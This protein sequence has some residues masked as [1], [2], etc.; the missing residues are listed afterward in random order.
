MIKIIIYCLLVYA[1]LL[2]VNLVESRIETSSR[3]I[4]TGVATCSADEECILHNKC[5]EVN[6]I[7]RK[8]FL[9]IDERKYLRSRLCRYI[10][11]EHHFC[12]KKKIEKKR[13]LP[14]VPVCGLVFSDRIFSS[15]EDPYIDKYPWTAI[16]MYTTPEN[17]IES[18]CGGSLITERHVLTAAHCNFRVP[19]T[20]KI[21]KVRLGE[22]DRRTNPDCMEFVNEQVC[23]DPFVDVQVMKVI[24]HPNYKKES[25][26]QFNDIAILELER[27]VKFTE[28][29]KP[30]C[31]PVDLNIRN[32]NFTSHSVE[33]SGFK[34]TEKDVE[35]SSPTKKV[36]YLY[37]VEQEK[38][39]ANYASMKVDVTNAHICAGIEEKKE[40][41]NPDSGGSLVKEGTFPSSKF[42]HYQLIG[43]QSFGPE[44][45][46]TTENPGLNF[47]NKLLQ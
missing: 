29:I 11:R 47:L 37:V 35:S 15:S 8:R 21:S 2:T 43:I 28:W 9:S 33:V 26:N 38:C 18:H 6:K 23:N 22:W 13:V 7:T 36:F 4:D 5:D 40:F 44:H 17:K 30:I 14:E 34:L 24:T 10:N 20:W 25:V 31:L 16:S 1:L 19:K 32:M 39:K 41:C 46:A 12:C 27:D 3:S 45:C 42:A